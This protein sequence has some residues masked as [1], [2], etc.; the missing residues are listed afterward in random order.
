MLEHLWGGAF[1]N[2]YASLGTVDPDLCVKRGQGA[3]GGGRGRIF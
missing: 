3:L 1:T 2:S